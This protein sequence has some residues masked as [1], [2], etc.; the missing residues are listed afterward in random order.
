MKPMLCHLNY[1]NI[2]CTLGWI[3]TS[4]PLLVRQVFLTPELR[5]QLAQ[6]VGIEPTSTSLESVVIAI[7]LILCLAHLEGFEP[8][9]SVLETV[10]LPLITKGV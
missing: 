5:E 2:T 7:I 9:S 10:M 6:D 1:K 3:R 8:P 4:D